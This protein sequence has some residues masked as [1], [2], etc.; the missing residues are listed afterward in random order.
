VRTLKRNLLID[1]V[2]LLAR[3]L[4]RHGNRVGAIMYADRVVGVIP[5]ESGKRHVLRLINDLLRQPQLRRAPPTDLTAVLEAALRTFR[6]RSLVFIISDFISAPGWTKPLRLLAQRHEVLAVRLSDPRE[7]E[8]PDI[9][10]VFLED[11]ETGEQLYINTHDRKFR[12][13]FTE[14]AR[15]REYELKANL[16][17]AGADL[18]ELSTD[19]DLA[20]QIVRYSILRKQRTR[21]QGAFA[22][23]PVRGQSLPGLASGGPGR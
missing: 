5:A 13:R 22:P 18:L 19:D 7:V 11:A 10:P 16:A 9:G 8:L 21:Q 17:R 23:A 3:L 4:T 2:T 20:Q 14:A 6:R 12:S 15:R 1:L